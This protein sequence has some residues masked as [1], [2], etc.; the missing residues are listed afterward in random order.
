MPRAPHLNPFVW[1]RNSFLAGVALVLPFVVT[2]WLIWAFVNFIDHNVTPLVPARWRG[3]AQAIPGAGV[4]LAIIALTLVGA[5]A[6]NFFGRFLLRESERI[7]SNLPIVRSIYGGSKQI[8][9]QVAAPERT[10]FK[11]AVLVEFPRAGAW[12]IGFVTNETTFE[13]TNGVGDDLVAVYVPQ[14][15]IP[16]SGFLIYFPRNALK[17]IALGPEEAL[18]RVIS[19]GIVKGDEQFEKTGVV[20]GE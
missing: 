17:P 4:V 15:P 16:T 18:K 1:L 8:F 10:S 20:N 7:I 13:V 5:L 11:Q 9:K 14:A 19:L 12:T 2:G 6:A 3:F